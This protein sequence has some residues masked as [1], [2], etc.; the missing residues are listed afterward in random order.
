MVLRKLQA[1]CKT[2]SDQELE[3]AAHSFLGLDM[4][5]IS[6]KFRATGGGRSRSTAGL[7]SE[8]PAGIRIGIIEKCVHGHLGILGVLG[9]T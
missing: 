8:P 6:H 4:N 1:Y 9:V 5:L 7:P 2:S 3:D